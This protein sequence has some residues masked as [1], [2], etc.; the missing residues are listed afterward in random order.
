MVI[1][2]TA[3][4]KSLVNRCLASFDSRTVSLTKEFMALRNPNLLKSSRIY[5]ERMEFEMLYPEKG[6]IYAAKRWG[7]LGWRYKAWQLKVFIRKILGSK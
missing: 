5:H 6:F 1:P 4:G 3:K 7:D 2:H